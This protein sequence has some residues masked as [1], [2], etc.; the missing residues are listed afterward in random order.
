MKTHQTSNQ[1]F[2]YANQGNRFAIIDK[3]VQQ[4]SDPDPVCYRPPQRTENDEC[5]YE[6]ELFEQ[7]NADRQHAER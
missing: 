3:L 4:H 2:L 6:F 5:L 7:K 1:P